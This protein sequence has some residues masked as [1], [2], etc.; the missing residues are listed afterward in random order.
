VA[1]RDVVA[2][3]EIAA[4]VR[5]GIL[6][7]REAVQD[8]LDRVDERDATIGAFQVVRRERALAEADEVAART[9]VADLPLAGVP[10]PDGR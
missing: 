10:T 3:S 9:D 8:A 5:K 6:A 2:A 1:D 4:R 7:P